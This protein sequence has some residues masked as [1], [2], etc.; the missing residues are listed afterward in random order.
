MWVQ[1]IPSPWGA[2]G[3]PVLAYYDAFEDAIKV[4][5]CN[6]HDCQGGPEIISYAAYLT[7]Q[8]GQDTVLEN[9]YWY[10]WVSSHRLF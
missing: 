4:A 2:D 8:E 6:S 5:K 3:F 1:E 7:H 10:R 9:F